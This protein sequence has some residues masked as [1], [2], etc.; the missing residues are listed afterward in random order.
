MGIGKQGWKHNAFISGKH[1]EQRQNFEG[2]RVTKTILRNRE[3][4]NFFFFDFLE[5]RG[6]EEQADLF[7]GNE[8]T[9]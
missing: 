2:N 8:G 9:V 1:L 3:H 7:Q 4:N 5:N 6:T